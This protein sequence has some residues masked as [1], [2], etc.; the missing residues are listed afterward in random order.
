MSVCAHLHLENIVSVSLRCEIFFFFGKS[1]KQNQT[2]TGKMICLE[3]VLKMPEK[4]EQN[5]CK[6]PYNSVLAACHTNVLLLNE[7]VLKYGATTAHTHEQ[8]SRW[9]AT[10]LKWTITAI[11]NILWC[12]NLHDLK[13][14][15]NAVKCQW[16]L[17]SGD[18]S[19]EIPSQVS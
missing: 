6:D 3:M 4:T 7:C 11:P 19:E 2:H 12:F 1:R 8:G 13:L 9:Q 15:Y 16:L 14:Y 5:V 10:P 17:S 18:E